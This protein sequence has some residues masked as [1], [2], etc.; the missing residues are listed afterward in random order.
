VPLD[1]PEICR[2][3]LR[4]DEKSSAAAAEYCLVS[5]FLWELAEVSWWDFLGS[6]L[7]SHLDSVLRIHIIF[8]RIRIQLFKINA[9]QHLY[10]AFHAISQCLNV[11]YAS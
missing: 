8:I 1:A 4:H 7:H 10:P 6:L 2:K 11:R 5:G 3:I 9:D